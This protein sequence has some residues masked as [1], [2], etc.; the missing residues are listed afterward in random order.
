MC[1]NNKVQHRW[2]SMKTENPALYKLLKSK[3][4]KK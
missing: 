1:K 2:E 3:V 4:N